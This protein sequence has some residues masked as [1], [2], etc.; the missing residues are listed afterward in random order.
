MAWP[1][2]PTWYKVETVK[3]NPQQLFFLRGHISMSKC[4]ERFLR[5]EKKPSWSRVDSA[6]NDDVRP[7]TF[8]WP[9]SRVRFLLNKLPRKL[10]QLFFPLK[11]TWCHATNLSNLLKRTSHYRKFH[12]TK[13]FLRHNIDTNGRWSIFNIDSWICDILRTLDKKWKLSTWRACCWQIRNAVVSLVVWIFDSW[14][15]ENWKQRSCIGDR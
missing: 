13:S 7:G 1:H 5:K 14:R 3:R 8:F 12:F 2:P 9:V 6:I 10:K 4:E 11:S 15:A